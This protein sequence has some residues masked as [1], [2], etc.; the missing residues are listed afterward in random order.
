M[1]TLCLTNDTL[2]PTDFNTLVSAVNYFVPLVVKAWNLEPVTITTTPTKG[3]W[4]VN[5][6]DK[7]RHSGASGY[8]LDTLGIPTA[9]CSPKASGRLWGHYTAPLVIL[10]KQIH[11]AL[12]TPGLVT[13]VCHEIAEMLVDSAISNFSSPDSK[14]RQWLTEVCDCVFGT[15][16]VHSIGTNVCIFPN[17]AMPNF[18][19]LGAK[20]PFDLLGIVKAPF[21]LTPQGYAYYKTP[22]GL[23]KV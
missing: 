11:G 14:G 8:H 17:I 23:V 10:K 21:T 12:Y 18:Y 20:A 19:L 5:I 3:A 9:W 22:K 6:T 4:I 15:Y 7:N 1:T 16:L 2:S 13:T